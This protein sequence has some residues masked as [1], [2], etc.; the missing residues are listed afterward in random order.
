MS[1]EICIKY[2]FR[3]FIRNSSRIIPF[4]NTLKK[5]LLA[6]YFMADETRRVSHPSQ[7][8]S[9]AITK[10]NAFGSDLFKTYII[11][12][13]LNNFSSLRSS[14]HSSFRI[15]SCLYIHLFISGKGQRTMQSRRELMQSLL[16]LLAPKRRL[17]TGT[18][19]VLI[20]R[21]K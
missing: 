9:F 19:R 2:Y 18:E 21:K 7:N 13:Q 10:R 17:I 3:F 16:L 8:G 4:V 14:I 1:L 12:L 5:T 11:S 15:R 20:V 6:S